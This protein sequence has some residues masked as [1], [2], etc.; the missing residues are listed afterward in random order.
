MPS[1]ES[2]V[3]VHRP[4]QPNIIISGINTIPREYHEFRHGVQIFPDIAINIEP[5]SYD[6]E[7][8]HRKY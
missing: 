1:T 4:Q 7:T 2:Y 3:M 5:E 6:Y 8:K